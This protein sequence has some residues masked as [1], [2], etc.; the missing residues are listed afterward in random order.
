MDDHLRTAFIQHRAEAGISTGRLLTLD[1]RIDIDDYDPKHPEALWYCDHCET[2]H[3]VTAQFRHGDEAMT[4]CR[5]CLQNALNGI[6]HSLANPVS[7]DDPFASPH[8]PRYATHHTDRRTQPH[9]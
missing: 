9:E 5:T 7:F 6:D 4:L 2:A 8:P 3:L 1:D